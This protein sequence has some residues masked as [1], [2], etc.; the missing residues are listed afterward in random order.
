MIAR[1]P[2][3]GVESQRK[4]CI[5]KSNSGP[6]LDVYDIYIIYI[7][8]SNIYLGKYYTRSNYRRK[9]IDIDRDEVRRLSVG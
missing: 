8:A 4:V 7:R 6:F 3:R 2:R 1:G 9:G 5:S